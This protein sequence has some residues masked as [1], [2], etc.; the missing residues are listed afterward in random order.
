MKKF[1]CRKMK[2]SVLFYALFFLILSACNEEINPDARSTEQ[3]PFSISVG[4]E[5]VYRV[6][7]LVYDQFK[8]DSFSKK[9][10]QLEKVVGYF[11]SVP[12]RSYRLEIFQKDS[13][14]HA[15]QY[16]RAD[17]IVLNTQYFTRTENNKTILYLS[18]PLFDNSRWDSNLFN[19]DERR[20]FR[21]VENGDEISFQDSSF[22]FFRVER[23]KIINPFQ[24]FTGSEVYLESVGLYQQEL[25][26]REF[27]FGSIDG[28][29]LKKQLIEFKQ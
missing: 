27:Q 6:D 22:R 19:A 15:W 17:K 24:E 16:V 13:L 29:K 12:N 20:T 25:V 11:D 23:T 4:S 18:F 2:H 9:I 8:K 1:W 14:H 3:L 10:Y 21:L 28:Y 26:E 5:H 7:S